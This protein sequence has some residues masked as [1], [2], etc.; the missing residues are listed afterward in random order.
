MAIQSSIYETHGEIIKKRL[1]KS[2]FTYRQSVILDPR[3]IEKHRETSK[4]TVHTPTQCSIN[5]HVSRSDTK[6]YCA[7]SVKRV[8]FHDILRWKRTNTVV[9]S[10]QDIT[11]STHWHVIQLFCYKLRNISR[12][13]TTNKYID[14]NPNATLADISQLKNNL[15]KHFDTNKSFSFH[16]IVCDVL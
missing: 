14:S 10:A 5:M 16:S 7:Q 4:C 12:K 1:N 3:Y 6:S 11:Y 8:T 9:D 15:S 13:N 2:P